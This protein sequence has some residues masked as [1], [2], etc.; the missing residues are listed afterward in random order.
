MNAP[1]DVTSDEAVFTMTVRDVAEQSGVAESAVRFYE[2]HGL[3]HA[4]R[5]HGNQRRFAPDAPCRIKVAKV[6]QRVGLSVR[7]I[8][9]VLQEVTPDA[10]PEVWASVGEKLVSEA[11]DRIRRLQTA[12]DDLGSAR[13]LCEIDD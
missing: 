3:V 12:L 8:A 10:G 13:R 7:E 6:A 11:E 2:R 4:R 9:D 1:R 5:T